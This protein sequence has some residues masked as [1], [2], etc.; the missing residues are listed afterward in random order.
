MLKILTVATWI[1]QSFFNCKRCTNDKIQFQYSTSTCVFIPQG[2][3]GIEGGQGSKLPLLQD[4][5]KEYTVQ[6]SGVQAIL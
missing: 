4:Y 1:L 3:N 6:N 5:E 2:M